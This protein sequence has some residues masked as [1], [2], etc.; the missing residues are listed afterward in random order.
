MACWVAASPNGMTSIGNGKRPSTSTHLLSSAIT[1]MRSD[2][3]ATIFS[4]NNAPPP[5][6]IMLSAGSISSA[7]STVRSSRSTS[8]SVVSRMPQR[9]A[10][11]RVA[12]EV[13]TPMTSSPAR[14]R[15]PRS[16]TK[17]FAVEPVPRPSFMPSRTCSS[18]RAAACR[19]SSS[20][21]TDL[22]KPPSP[23]WSR[24]PRFPG[25]LF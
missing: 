8:S 12:S 19:F 5:P 9:T 17:C 18:A 23:P 20:I 24:D 22:T 15:S 16:S 2:A 4:R 10:S 25:G 6:L 13:G 14:T 1:I 11:A 21:F 3:D 7:P